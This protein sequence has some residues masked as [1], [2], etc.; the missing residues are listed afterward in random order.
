MNAFYA[1]PSDE[2]TLLEWN[3]GTWVQVFGAGGTPGTG[4]D[5]TSSGAAL[6]DMAGMTETNTLVGLTGAAAPYAA[7]VACRAHGPDWYLPAL[8]GS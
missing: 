1:W 7:A 8:G 6:A 4:I 5:Y 2:S 3:N